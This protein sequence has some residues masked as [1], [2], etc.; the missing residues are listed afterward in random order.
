MHFLKTRKNRNA[1]QMDTKQNET[2]HFNEILLRNKKDGLK[3][4][5]T[6]CMPFKCLTLSEGEFRRLHTV[7]GSICIIFYKRQNC[8]DGKH[9]Y[10][11]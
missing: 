7:C 4:H 9:N 3:I 10:G 8:V 5:S 1:L 6:T 11:F 2:E